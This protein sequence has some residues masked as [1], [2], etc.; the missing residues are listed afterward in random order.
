M[1]D[2]A[3][4]VSHQTC[5]NVVVSVPVTAIGT[6]H[7]VTVQYV[8]S[9]KVPDVLSYTSHDVPVVHVGEHGNPCSV[10]EQVLAL[11]G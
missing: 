3:H 1:A 10:T 2:L 4:L 6:G 8:M 9:M 5:D 7:N 11:S